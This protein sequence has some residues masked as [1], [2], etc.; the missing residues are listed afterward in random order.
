M[1]LLTFK[2]RHSHVLTI[3]SVR[4]LHILS[5]FY[6]CEKFQVITMLVN[7]KFNSLFSSVENN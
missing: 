7:L 2:V 5:Y 4:L 6:L 3:V 1:L